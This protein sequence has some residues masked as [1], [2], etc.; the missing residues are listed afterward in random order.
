M[1]IVNVIR[2][3]SPEVHMQSRLTVCSHCLDIAGKSLNQLQQYD[4][5]FSAK[6]IE[7]LAFVLKAPEIVFEVERQHRKRDILAS[8]QMNPGRP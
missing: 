7:A 5:Q 2:P 6:L 8:Q 4:Q 3:P 1:P